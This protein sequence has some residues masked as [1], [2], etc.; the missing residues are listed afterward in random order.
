[1]IRIKYFKMVYTYE[2]KDIIA[3]YILTLHIHT[4]YHPY[5]VNLYVSYPSSY[6]MILSENF[7]TI[8]EAAKRFYDIC[9]H[10]ENYVKETEND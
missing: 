4:A 3:D 2:S 6:R 10:I 1:M 5:E 7:E 8:K 9:D